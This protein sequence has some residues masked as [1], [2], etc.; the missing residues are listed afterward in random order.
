M[1]EREREENISEY[2]CNYAMEVN[3]DNCT[4]DQHGLQ[5]NIKWMP[6]LE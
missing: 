1:K 2:H 6:V 5:Y 4:N 3:D